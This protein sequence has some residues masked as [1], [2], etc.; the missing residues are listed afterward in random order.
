MHITA[1]NNRDSTKL[2]SGDKKNLDD[3]EDERIPKKRSRFSPSSCIP[4][5]SVI[6]L[7]LLAMIVIWVV[8]YVLTERLSSRAANQVIESLRST[9]TELLVEKTEALMAIPQSLGEVLTSFGSL[10]VFNH[11]SSLEDTLRMCTDIWARTP[12]IS[13]LFWASG[14]GERLAGVG[15]AGG[16]YYLFY[17]WPPENT[18]ANTFIPIDRDTLETSPDQAF[19]LTWGGCATCPFGRS[20]DSPQWIEPYVPAGYPLEAVIISL[21]F[22]IRDSDDGTYLGTGGIVSSTHQLSEF[23]K[24]SLL[25]DNSVAYVVSRA[26]TN[27]IAESLPGGNPIF[28]DE[29]DL[30]FLKTPMDYDDPVISKSSQFLETQ[31]VWDRE[32]S[33]ERLEFKWNSDTIGNT[34]LDVI[35]VHQEYGIDYVIVSVVPEDDFI[36]DIKRSRTASIIIFAV[37]S[38]VLLLV[39]I[40]AILSL[41]IPLISISKEL[42]KIKHFKL[43]QVRTPHYVFFREIKIIRDTF[44]TVVTRLQ[45][46]RR[47]L[48]QHVLNTFSESM[49]ESSEL[50]PSSTNLVSNYEYGVNTASDDDEHESLEAD[51]RFALGLETMPLTVM[52]AT[53]NNFDQLCVANGSDAWIEIHGALLTC[54]SKG[55]QKGKGTVISTMGQRMVAVFNTTIKQK[56]HVKKAAESALLISK[57]IEQLNQE[58]ENLHLSVHIGVASGMGWFGNMGNDTIRQASLIGEPL[59]KAKLLSKFCEEIGVQIL[60]DDI[61]A[62]SAKAKMLLRPVDLVVFDTDFHSRPSIS[63][64]NQTNLVA[65]QL[66]SEKKV[67]ANEWM[68]DMANDD[69]EQYWK[70]MTCAFHYMM[71]GNYSEALKEFSKAQH[72]VQSSKK[73]GHNSIGIDHS[74]DDVVAD[75]LLEHCKAHQGDTEPYPG[76]YVSMWKVKSL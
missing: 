21:I 42:E 53:I 45:Q 41:Y 46:Y 57:E 33:N 12:G 50:E 72:Q 19:N 36:L 75:R 31:Q 44:D 27:L 30:P 32:A 14:S 74:G 60:V 65:Y 73:F 40:L 49:E 28:Y 13:G 61:V 52:V 24:N 64:G 18:G 7:L 20:I 1:E 59:N 67:T 37:G 62:K 5:G 63:P 25:S 4:I 35:F 26:S 47:F 10:Q 39:A 70:T 69:Q 68:Y 54:F 11:S 58:N 23:L 29:N 8:S 22:P 56:A 51:N 38:A 16:R 76:T 9:N 17:H 71:E 55:V 15:N 34:L 48:P 2:S 66:V 43:D 6:I 3:A